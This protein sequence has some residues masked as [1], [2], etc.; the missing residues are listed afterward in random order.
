MITE[1]RRYLNPYS[2]HGAATLDVANTEHMKSTHPTADVF[3][4]T[5]HKH[6]P[7]PP[8]SRFLSTHPSTYLL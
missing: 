8:T 6:S 5:D 3:L 7:P 1:E 4:Y 2:V